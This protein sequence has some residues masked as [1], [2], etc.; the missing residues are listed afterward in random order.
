[1]ARQQAGPSGKDLHP[2]WLG[3]P[4]WSLLRLPS[5]EHIIKDLLMYSWWK[6]MTGLGTGTGLGQDVSLDC[7]AMLKRCSPAHI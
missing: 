2:L 5:T 6:E 1:M 4:G 3:V 7:G